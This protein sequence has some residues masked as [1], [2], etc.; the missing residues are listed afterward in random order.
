M[1]VRLTVADDGTAG[2]PVLGGQ[3]SFMMARPH[4]PPPLGVLPNL[5]EGDAEPTEL[6]GEVLEDCSAR[7]VAQFTVPHAQRLTLERDGRAVDGPA[8]RPGAAV[9]SD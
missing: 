4:L 3:V 9:G 5:G 7:F 1:L 8:G 6:G 2:G